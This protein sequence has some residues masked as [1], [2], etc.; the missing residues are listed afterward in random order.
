MSGLA[1]LATKL[2][3]PLR[4]G[5]MH[6]RRLVQ[7]LDGATRHRLTLLVAPAGWGKTS[8]LADWHTTSRRD[9]VC[10]LAL[11]PED[12]DPIR[13]WTYLISA[14]RTVLPG[15]G[16]HALGTL[17]VRGRALLDAAL[18]ALLNDLAERS[19]DVHLVLDDYHVLSD[20][21]LHR[22]VAFLL[23]HQPARLHLV[24]ATR[25]DPP[26]PFGRL[27]VHGEMLEIRT[28]DLAFT[29]SE[30]TTMLNG[31]LA[32]RLDARDIERLGA[33]T[34]GWA[35]GLYLAGLSLREH[36][37]R[38]AFVEEFHG[39]DRFVLD[40][41]GTEV[42]AAQPAELRTFLLETSILPRLSAPLCQ[43]V[44]GRADSAALL[45]RIERS[46]LFLVPLDSEQRWFRYH[47]L[48]GELLRHELGVAEPRRLPELHRRAAAWFRA[49]GQVGEAIDHAV[50]AGDV[51]DAVELVAGH[52]N[53]WFNAG[54]LATV[55]SWLD[56]LPSPAQLTDPRLCV[57]RA[58]L[59]LD[60]GRLADVDRWLSA[61]DAC[62]TPANPLSLREV[63]VLRTVH[64][65][66]IGDVSASHTAA[67]RVLELN[68]GEVCFAGTV[69]HA[70][71]GVTLFWKGE[72]AAALRPLTE[73]LAL[74]RHT[75]NLL[76]ETYVMGYLA[77]THVE[78]GALAEGQRVAGAALNR[79][80]APG[81]AE[82]FV[83]GLPQLAHALALA[84]TGRLEQAGLAAARAVQLA[85]RGAGRLELGL[86]LATHAHTLLAAGQDGTPVLAE[87][88]RVA[89]AC[90]DPGWLPERL[91]RL[92]R[93][94][95]PVGPRP[96]ASVAVKL[97]DRE[98]E[99]L[100]LLAGTLSQ[101]EIGAVLHLSLNTVKTHNR[102]LY[103]KLGA[104][105]RAEAVQ[106]A[107]QHGLL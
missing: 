29:D 51:G 53:T 64:R 88:K 28:G 106:R 17:R 86:A 48:F 1:V 68:Q 43:A 14:V 77:L 70:L 72:L 2:A 83:T 76:G 63:A 79:A 23:A 107:R 15:V 75:N 93:A 31:A 3:P 59:L 62:T 95:T 40:F 10:W 9:R 50:A 38:A 18:P 30:A 11:D 21:E 49:A 52:W 6:R 12:S 5:L 87:A 34:E 91:T 35:A 89:R 16:E 80:L 67:R 25:T 60:A 26:L 13:F 27:R 8:L 65:F 105:S 32:L 19:E 58:W 56:H 100:P 41:L 57:A 24:I 54:R 55:E 84:G 36:T 94:M 85:R 78:R 104:G 39:T 82:H 37:D 98:Q 61:A 69:A 74:A 96:V 44:T 7:A 47:R 66:K 101:R 73:A 4:R 20:P 103:R 22:S 90:R 42:L 33:R 102:A 97:T 99:L 92:G 45:E 81:V 46:N 71:L